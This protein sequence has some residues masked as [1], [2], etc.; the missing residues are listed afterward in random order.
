MSFAQITV[1]SISR[2]A[3]Q[4]GQRRVTKKLVRAVPF[5]GAVVAAA[6]LMRAVRRK[7]MFGGTVDTV[8]DFIPFVGGAKNAAEIVRGRDFIA[9]RRV[10][11]R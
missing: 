7:G 4:Y 6:T 11:T 9:D 10:I 5:L 3:M 2:Q 1:M 8:L